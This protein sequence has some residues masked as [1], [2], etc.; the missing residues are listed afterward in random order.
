MT[1]FRNHNKTT[2]KIFINISK[3]D[4]HNKSFK[5]QFSNIIMKRN[6][7]ILTF[8]T[9]VFSS[10][11]TAGPVRG[12][13]QLTEGLGEVIVILIRFIGDTIL[14]IESFDEFLF[15]KLLLFLLILI[16]TFTVISK[17]TI[18]EGTENKP[19]KPIQWIISS[20]V[21]I[22]AIR[23]LPD[24]FIQVI[25]LQYGTLAVGLT[26]FLPLM[27]YFFF[28]HQSGIGPFGR[29]AGW[30]VFAAS[31]FALWSFRYEDIGSANWIYWIAIGF[32]I[33]SFLYDKAIHEYFGL[34]SIRQVRTERRVER[35][36]EA[37]RKLEELEDNRKYFTDREY[38]TQKNRYE[39]IIKNNI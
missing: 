4:Q 9:I 38:E 19:N 1:L 6:G 15:A 25:L 27:I 35:R 11:V 20:A 31:F 34:S 24:N 36:A 22:L 8:L 17:N 18:F 14:S 12:I 3:L 10:L 32:V 28:I 23:Y 29:R 2:I 7:G 30:V 39:K 37:Q 13:E 21:S 33:I 16:I 5:L 26:V